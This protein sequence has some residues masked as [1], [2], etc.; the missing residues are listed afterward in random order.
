VCSFDLLAP[1]KTLPVRS[2]PGDPALW[3]NPAGNRTRK[4]RRLCEGQ[5]GVGTAKAVITSRAVKLLKGK[6]L[7]PVMSRRKST[8]L[9]L[10]PLAAEAYVPS[11]EIVELDRCTSLSTGQHQF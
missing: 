5:L 10:A 7:E 2:M 6:R 3:G 9:Y 8:A 11:Y 1:I 4:N